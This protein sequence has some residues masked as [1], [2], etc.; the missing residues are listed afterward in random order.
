MKRNVGFIIGIVLLMAVVW[1]LT[2]IGRTVIFKN[3]N[4]IL[5]SPALAIE[6]ILC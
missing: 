6:K 4:T 5:Y 3:E 1:I 2:V